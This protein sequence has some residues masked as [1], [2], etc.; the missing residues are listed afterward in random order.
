MITA[1]VF[2]GAVSLW[3]I[4][5]VSALLTCALRYF[6]NVRKGNGLVRSDLF[7]TVI[8][9]PFALRSAHANG[10]PLHFATSPGATREG[11]IKVR[12]RPRR[13]RL[14]YVGDSPSRTT[15]FAANASYF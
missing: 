15:E 2:F 14:L 4:R 13:A 8:L 6:H 1:P 5:L 9:D 11:C 3:L 7:I 12:A 10:A